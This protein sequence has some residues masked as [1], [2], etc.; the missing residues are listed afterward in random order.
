MKIIAAGH[1]AIAVPDLRHIGLAGLICCNHLIRAAQC[2]HCGPEGQGGGDG[3][4][5]PDKT[6]RPEGAEVVQLREAE[7]ERR[8]GDRQTRSQDDVRRVGDRRVVGRFFVLSCPPRFVVPADE[9]Y[10]VVG[11]DTQ[12]QGDEH[13]HRERRDA[14]DM[15]PDEERDDAARRRQDEEHTHQR[16]EGSGHR[17]VSEQQHDDDDEHRHDREREHAGVGRVERI[18]VQCCRPGHISVEAVRFWDFGH[19]VSD[20]VNRPT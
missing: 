7:A 8:P 13:V 20:S 10:A 14:K 5:H 1:L 19:I 4:D 6:G 12:D 15:Q 3:H 11:G 2:E 18:R 17:A 16:Y 9:K